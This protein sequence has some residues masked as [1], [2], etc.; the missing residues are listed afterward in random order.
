MTPIGISHTYGRRESM[1]E[2]LN[3]MEFGKKI[4][5]DKITVVI[6]SAHPL[7]TKRWAASP[8]SF[9][10][11]IAYSYRQEVTPKIIAVSET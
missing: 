11:T 6:I 9:G 8:S 2:K 10:N 1:F 4:S 5:T 3:K 7:S